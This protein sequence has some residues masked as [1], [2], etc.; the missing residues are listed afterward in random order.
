MP[1]LN[2]D[3]PEVQRWMTE[4]C[5]YWIEVFDIDGYR[6]DAVWGVTAR[7]PEYTQQ[8]RLALKRIKP[9]I[10]MLAEDKA[11]WH[12]VFDER[13][14]VAFDWASS[15]G[16]VSQWSWQ[17]LYHDY[18]Q[19][20]NVTIFNSWQQGRNQRM[21]DAL[22]NNEEGY[23][24][25]AKILRFMENNDTQRFIRHHG[26][27]R[28][29]MVAALE[30]SLPGVPLIYNGQEIGFDGLHP[31]YGQPIFKRG[32]SIQ[33]L[34]TKGLFSYYQHLIKLKKSLP[35]LHND[36]FE[37]LQISPSYYVFA[38]RRWH[39]DQNIFTVLNIG[40]QN[41]TADLSIPIN[42]LELDSMKTYYLTELLTGEIISGTAQD[43]QIINLDLNKYTAKI[44]ILAD[45]VTVTDVEEI[46]QSNK[47]RTF[48]LMQNYPNP[49]NP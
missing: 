42:R 7:N 18:W 14:D 19:D 1:N 13:F 11:S 6:F 12:N 10:L 37:E 21:R 24:Q 34:D 5:K 28:T 4:I 3:N 38:I 22:T 33:S 9:E 23:H 41:E 47:I 16:W 29:K 20:Q 31:Y 43:L 25:S 30:L 27:E 17:V 2:Y 15:E 49:F 32:Q 44:Y 40:D 45:T 46:V 35:A 39:G 36:N 26:L 8:L 48:A